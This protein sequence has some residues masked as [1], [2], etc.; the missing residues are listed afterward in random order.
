VGQRRSR[1]SALRIL[2]ALYTLPFG[3][4]QEEQAGIYRVL[5]LLFMRLHA[6]HHIYLGWS[7]GFS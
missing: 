2:Y 3:Y 1:H 5:L 6:I 4:L 7:C